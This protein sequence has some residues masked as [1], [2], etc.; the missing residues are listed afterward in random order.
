MTIETLL[1]RLQKVKRRS[2]NSWLACC[3]AHLDKTPS[4]SIKDDGG[5]I[6]LHCFGQGCGVDSIA[7]AI[8]LDLS[9]LFPPTENY[10]NDQGKKIQQRATHD[11]S[12]VLFGLVLEVVAVEIICE[13][14]ANAIGIDE[15][16][17]ARLKLAS[18]RMRSA[19]AYATK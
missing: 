18:E 5:K 2:N 13:E 16:T 9:D 8:G 10:I 11:A 19:V 15:F 14:L 3:P 4:L 7:A 12:N 17:K 6:L 1:T